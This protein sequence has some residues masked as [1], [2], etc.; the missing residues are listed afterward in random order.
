VKFFG[1]GQPMPNFQFDLN[2][3]P[4]GEFEEVVVNDNIADD[5]W[6]PWPAMQ[7]QP[8]QP[9]AP[10][11]IVN[12][13]EEQFSYQF[14]GLEDL[15]SDESVG[16]FNDIIIPQAVHFP[17]EEAQDHEEVVLALPAFPS[18]DPFLEGNNEQG[19][20]NMNPDA[21][22]NIIVGCM[23]HLDQPVHDPAYEDFMAKKR[24]SSWAQLCPPTQTSSLYQNHGQLSLWACF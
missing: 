7:V 16:L 22:E 8:E 5:G 17:Q 23:L 24:C 18:A 9:P 13:E 21:E 14:F 12:N 19:E 11:P 15:P 6:D 10:V 2:I 4:I 20:E 3:P 1:L